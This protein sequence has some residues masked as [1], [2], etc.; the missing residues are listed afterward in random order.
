MDKSYCQSLDTPISDDGKTTVE[1]VLINE[2]QPF[3]DTFTKEA[4]SN[5]LK[6]LSDREYKVI[7]EYYGLNGV[8]E[9]TIKDIAQEMNLGDERI[10]Q[11]R[12]SAIKKLKNRCG[13][14]LL[15]LL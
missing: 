13:K 15:T 10:R 6:I 4:I 9:R 3:S 7:T 1:D 8:E 5:A 12:K 14:T 11:L 2:I